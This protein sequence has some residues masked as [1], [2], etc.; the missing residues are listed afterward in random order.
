MKKL[1]KLSKFFLNTMVLK[2]LAVII[3][4]IAWFLIAINTYEI[5][6]RVVNGVKITLDTTASA[7]A[8]LQPITDQD[9]TVRVKVSGPR[10]IIGNLTSRDFTVIATPVNPALFDDADVYQVSLTAQKTDPALDVDIIGVVDDDENVMD[11]IEIE[12]DMVTSRELDIEV[13][14]EGEA[15]YPDD[16]VKLESYASN[17]T[18]AVSGPG[19]SIEVIDRCIAT[20]DVSGYHDQSIQ[21]EVILTFLDSS[22]NIITDDEIT[23]HNNR[24]TV[25]VPILKKSQLTLK[26][27]PIN[28][29]S[30]LDDEM[31]DRFV[32]TPNVIDIAGTA[33]V[34][35]NQKSEFTVGFVDLSGIDLEDDTTT[36]WNYDIDLGINITNLDSSTLSVRLDTTGLVTRYF[37][38][39]DITVINP[40]AGY[41]AEVLN[42]AIYQVAIIADE[43]TMDTLSA[44]N[45]RAV[46]DL[47]GIS[48]TAGEVVRPVEI[49]LPTGSFA[50]AVGEDYTVTV[51]VTRSS[52]DS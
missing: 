21:Q 51:D 12:Y 5:R 4:I 18:V 24:T 50:W 6:E 16:Y 40:Q 38:I 29:P 17:E 49:I 43:D 46:V 25:T 2:I 8:G 13:V 1:P 19:S 30:G 22:G 44:Q 47:Q 27:E 14:E 33:N 52:T 31:M 20:I 9:I 35:D 28:G 45:I 42:E 34:I 23:M 10:S 15:G 48:I 36:E 11:I 37:D 39:S 3:A 32:L 7:Q 41:D 26:V